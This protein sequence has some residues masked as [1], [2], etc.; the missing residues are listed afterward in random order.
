MG[1]DSSTGQS[2]TLA[3]PVRPPMRAVVLFANFF[4]IILAYYQVKA[5]SRSLVLEYFNADAFP[6]LWMSRQGMFR[7]V[8]QQGDTV[9]PVSASGGWRALVTSRYLLLIGALL[10]CAQLAQPVVEIQ[11]LNAI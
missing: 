9:S 10:V 5:A 8:V 4:L 7:E 6:W 2:R 11:F 1:Q 3:P